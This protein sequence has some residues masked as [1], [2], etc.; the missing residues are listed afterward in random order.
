M[1]SLIA[2]VSGSFFLAYV[3]TLVVERYAI[4]KELLDIPNE[5]SS[6]TTTTPRGGGVAIVV[7]FLIVLVIFL[8]TNVIEASN[9][10]ALL[11]AG[12]LVAAVGFWDD[13]G[14][15][16]RKWRLL[17]HL[18]AATWALYWIGPIPPLQ[19]FGFDILAGWIEAGFLILL[20]VWLLNMFNFMDGIDGIAGSEAVFVASAGALF[21]W[22]SGNDGHALLS[23]SLAMA[24]MGFLSWNWPPARIFMGD[25][26][27]GFLGMILG[28]LAY[29][30][31]A[32]GVSLWVWLILMSVF[33]ADA[34]LTLLRRI[35]QGE[36]WYEAHRTHAY[37]WASRK[38]GHLRTTLAV[39]A[40]NVGWLLPL[41]YVA[42]SYPDMGFFIMVIANVPLITL[43]CALSAGAPES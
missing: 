19:F 4:S 29:S 35:Y 24:S 20:L 22:L 2:L 42:F 15:V 17:A 21:S 12:G 18:V 41:A 9:A 34:G 13:H 11:G 25:A 33:L 38:W 7:T 43:A 31:F 39:I 8:L 23:L 14:N 3:L 36:R 28:V 1:F 5:R 30:A 27:S 37:Q 10:F 32:E 16:P 40:I 26:G 6:H